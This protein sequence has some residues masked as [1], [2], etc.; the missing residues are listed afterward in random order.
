MSPDRIDHLLRIY[1]E[2]PGS[3]FYRERIIE[4]RFRFGFRLFVNGAAMALLFYT[5]HQWIAALPFFTLSFG[6]D[7]HRLYVRIFSGR[8]PLDGPR[9][10]WMPLIMALAK[11]GPLWLSMA[12]ILWFWGW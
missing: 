11:I 9:S 5:H 2:E 1:S 3:E 7:V 4:A 12:I 6:W 10:P 8:E